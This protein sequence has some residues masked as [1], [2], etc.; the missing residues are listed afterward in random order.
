MTYDTTRRGFIALFS[1]E[2]TMKQV[3]NKG[4]MIIVRAYTVRI[5]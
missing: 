2:T 3:E 4:N 1:G 5:Q